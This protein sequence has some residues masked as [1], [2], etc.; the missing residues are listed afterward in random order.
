MLGFLDFERNVLGAARRSEVGCTSFDDEGG[1]VTNIS[2]TGLALAVILLS[3][4]RLNKINKITGHKL[5]KTDKMGK[6]MGKHQHFIR[7]QGKFNKT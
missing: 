6:L 3:Y 2:T 4:K 7:F 5:D 1:A